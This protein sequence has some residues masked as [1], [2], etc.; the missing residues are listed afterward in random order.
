MI[1]I[2]LDLP[3][4]LPFKGL[5][6]DHLS[7]SAWHVVQTVNRPPHTTLKA[8]TIQFSKSKHRSSA[9]TCELRRARWLP[10]YRFVLADLVGGFGGTAASRNRMVPD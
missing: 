1:A 8:E 7:K 6:D 3:L 10:R 2:Y 5:R 4:A 9:P